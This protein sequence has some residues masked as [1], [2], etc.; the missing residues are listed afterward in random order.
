MPLARG[1]Y[2][3][4]FC[5]RTGFRYNL[6]DLVDEVK[7]GVR[8]GLK[9]G[10]DVADQDHP[11]NFL[12]RLRIH[13]PQSLRDPRPERKIESV[14]V[15]FP[16]FNS[17]TVQREPVPFLRGVVGTPSVSGAVI[18]PPSAPNVTTVTLTGVAGTGAVAPVFFSSGL[19]FTYDSTNVTLD[20]T[21]ETFDEG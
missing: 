6:N 12:G 11:Q 19:S 4:G 20:T 15:T 1:K 16:V 3:Y 9:V 14:T 2:A 8:T 7:N 21:N 17:A 18:V 5:D 13:D 10:R